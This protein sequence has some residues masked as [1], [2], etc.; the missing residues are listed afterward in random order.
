MSWA[1]GTE[2]IETYSDVIDSR[3]VIARIEYLANRE[4]LAESSEVP[5]DEDYG[6]VLD[7]DER[8]ELAALRKLAEE[9][10]GCASDW[11]YG[12]TLIRDSYFTEYAQELAED[13]CEMPS[14]YRWPFS[15]ID[16][17]EA[18]AALQM[19]YTSVEFDGVTYWIC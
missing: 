12:E 16:W 7:I 5:E 15:H 17:D 4:S 13:A 8:K 19:E 9:C 14:E 3:E 10:E 6:E 1:D 2:P 18:A 11:R